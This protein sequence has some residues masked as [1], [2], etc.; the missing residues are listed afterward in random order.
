MIGYLQNLSNVKLALWCY[1]IWYCL[2][3]ARY[4][5]STISIW[6]SALG[7]SFFVGVVN[8]LNLVSGGAKPDFW[9]AARCYIAPF[10]VSSYSA[11]VKGKG[12]LLVFPPSVSE[13]LLGATI[14]GGFC[15][16]VLLTRRLRKPE[17]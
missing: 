14:I 4:F 7:L 9:Q 3:V 16:A 17:P 11:V 10:C 6:L 5:D 13:N 12:F 1:L 2:I 15:F 8:Y